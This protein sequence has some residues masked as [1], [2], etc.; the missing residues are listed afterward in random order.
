MLIGELSN[1]NV[2]PLPTKHQRALGARFKGDRAFHVEL[3]FR[4]VGFKVLSMQ[5]HT[6]VYMYI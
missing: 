4:N 1:V 6:K 2:I 3:E 5:W